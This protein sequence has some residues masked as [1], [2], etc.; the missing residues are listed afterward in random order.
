MKNK[1]KPMNMGGWW[2]NTT[3]PAKNKKC[4]RLNTQGT[5]LVWPASAM[6]LKA[7]KSLRNTTATATALTSTATAALA[8]KLV[9]MKC[10]SQPQVAAT[11]KTGGA[12]N[13]VKVPPMETL[14]SSTPRVAYFKR[15][16]MPR[17]KNCS[18]SINAPK[19]MAAGSVMN[20]PSNGTKH[21][22]TTYAP[23]LPG[24]GSRRASQLTTAE[25]VCN[26][27]RVP[28]ITMMANTNKGSVK[29][30]ESM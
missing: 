3:T 5:G 8:P 28:A 23:V 25:V 15:T 21:K 17:A 1:N 24:N 30:R 13:G 18:D 11:I 14:T 22:I 10:R 6:G 19:V 2:A 20:E 9:S 16:E 12:A 29:L 27:G 7:A 4:T 26:T